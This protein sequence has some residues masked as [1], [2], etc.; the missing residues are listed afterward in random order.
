MTETISHCEKKTSLEI[1]IS[2]LINVIKNESKILIPLLNPNV[3]PI[4]NEGHKHKRTTSLQSSLKMSNKDIEN[5]QDT[6]DLYIFDI[7]I[8][9]LINIYYRKIKGTSYFVEQ[10]RGIDELLKDYQ[11]EGHGFIRDFIHILTKNVH[12]FLF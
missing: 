12:Y 3:L 9:K 5:K 1:N 4:I 7:I 8:Q 2:D 11:E 10:T 6:L